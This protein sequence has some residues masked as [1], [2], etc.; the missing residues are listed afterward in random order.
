MFAVM[1]STLRGFRRSD[2]DAAYAAAGDGRAESVAELVGLTP[3]CA[4]A[5]LRPPPDD[6]S[7]RGVNVD[8]IRS[9]AST[10]GLPRAAAAAHSARGWPEAQAGRPTIRQRHES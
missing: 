4:D 7:D 2:L 9:S 5:G 1:S 8:M 6:A 3:G 10:M